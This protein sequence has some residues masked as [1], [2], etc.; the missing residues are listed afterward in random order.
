MFTDVCFDTARQ[1]VIQAA[2][3]KADMGPGFNELYPERV[4]KRVICTLFYLSLR[5]DLQRDGTIPNDKVLKKA[6]QERYKTAISD[7]SLSRT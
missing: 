4:V 2:R 7:W 3:Y 1:L 6:A 5:S